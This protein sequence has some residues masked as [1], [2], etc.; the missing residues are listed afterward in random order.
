MFSTLLAVL[1]RWQSGAATQARL[2]RLLQS[3]AGI[4]AGMGVAVL[5]VLNFALATVLGVSLLLALGIANTRVGARRG[6][7]ALRAACVQLLNPVV[8]LALA[9]ILPVAVSS[10]LTQQAEQLL[11]E[12]SVLRSNTVPIL[13]LFY[14]PIVLQLQTS[15]VLLLTSPPQAHK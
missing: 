15:L 1:L 2:G 12:W 4:Q 3:F 11:L 7:I 10:V 13:A 5:S 6:S 9:P 8:W 14:L